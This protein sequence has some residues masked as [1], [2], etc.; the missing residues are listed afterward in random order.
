MNSKP[1]LISCSHTQGF[2]C[3]IDLAQSS[4]LLDTKSCFH[5]LNFI[6]SCECS[7]LFVHF[8]GS[9]FLLRFIACVGDFK[10]ECSLLKAFE[11]FSPYQKKL[12]TRI[13]KHVSRLVLH[14][15]Q[16]AVLSKTAKNHFTSQRRHQPRSNRPNL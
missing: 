14:S 11:I 9:I 2:L 8:L 16:Q 7:T 3:V 13:T 6:W 5:G 12:R 1:F 15:M 10:S 4:S